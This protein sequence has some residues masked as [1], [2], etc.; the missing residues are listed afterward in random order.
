MTP[1]PRD[2]DLKNG[3]RRK[4]ERDTPTKQHQGKAWASKAQQDWPVNV[5]INSRLLI[6]KTEMG[7]A[8]YYAK[9]GHWLMHRGFPWVKTRLVKSSTWTC[10][11]GISSSSSAYTWSIGEMNNT[12]AKGI[13]VQCMGVQRAIWC[14]N[15]SIL[16][17]L[18]P[19]SHFTKLPLS[20]LFIYILA[21]HWK[22]YNMGF[23]SLTR[24]YDFLQAL[25]SKRRH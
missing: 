1:C 18:V 7:E 2:T 12:W 11:T 21:K 13:M 14:M 4:E 22:F 17:N 25:C 16:P 6:C 15:M 3:S 19:K 10:S 20:F 5:D 9:P 8:L 24:V 23:V